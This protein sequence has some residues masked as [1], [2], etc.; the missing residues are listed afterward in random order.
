MT[1]TVGN[2]VGEARAELKDV[3]V[4]G[5]AYS[6]TDMTR[7]CGEGVI[8]LRRLRP[9]T[10]FDET[11]QVYDDD[12]VWA[13]LSEADESRPLPGE[14][15]FYPGIVAYIVSRC[16]SRDITDQANMQVAAIWLGRFTALAGG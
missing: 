7:Y 4:G 3:N 2:A 15:R 16:L 1:K 9:A 11:F 13:G 8:E 12:A 14:D 10:R 6:S 5:Y